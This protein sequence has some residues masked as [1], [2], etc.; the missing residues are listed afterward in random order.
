MTYNGQVRDAL[1]FLK[2]SV[3]NH[4]GF[5]VPTQILKAKLEQQLFLSKLDQELN[6]SSDQSVSSIFYELK[7]GVSQKSKISTNISK[8][9]S[10]DKSDDI[11]HVRHQDVSLNSIVNQMRE[12]D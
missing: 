12:F 9:S 5:S 3:K 6:D 10:I 4:T 11:H 7:S 2:F 8:H 1:K